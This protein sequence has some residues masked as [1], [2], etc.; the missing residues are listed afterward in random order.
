M[1]RPRGHQE[2][3]LRRWRDLIHNTDAVGSGRSLA[4]S[5]CRFGATALMFEMGLGCLKTLTFN[6]RIEFPSRFRRCGNQLL[7]QLLSEE[8]NKENNSVHPW[9]ERVF[10]QPRSLADILI[11]FR[12]TSALNPESGH[13]NERLLKELTRPSQSVRVSLLLAL[14]RE[15]RTLRNLL[16][17]LSLWPLT[18]LNYTK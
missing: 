13:T 15:I 18:F 4:A 14:P 1:G 5:R 2:G 6:L 8:G 7:W 11:A 12:G 16:C 17:K 10:T 9:L 3:Y